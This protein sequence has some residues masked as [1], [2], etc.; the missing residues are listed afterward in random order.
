VY[1]ILGTLAGIAVTYVTAFVLSRKR[2][3]HRYW[4]MSL[5]IITW[6]FDAGIIPQYI[7]YNLFGFVTACGS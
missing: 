7:I 1:T 6:V 3:V 5:F 4:I 2:F